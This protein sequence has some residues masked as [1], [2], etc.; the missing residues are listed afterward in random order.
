[1]SV[2]PQVFRKTMSC[3]AT[4]VTVVTARDAARA[5]VGL[6]VSA[7]SSLS[8]D[9]PLV[10]VCLD[11]RV[12]NLEAFRAG[13]FAVNVLAEDQS[14]ISQRF[15]EK[16]DDR[17][18]GVPLISGDSEPPLLAGT[19]AAVVCNTHQVVPSGDH[20]IIIGSVTAAT[21]DPDRRPLL[22][23]SGRYGRLAT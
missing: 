18:D 2:D 11:R 23:F 5:P 14:G 4:G 3:F 8:L 16:R 1:M 13:P 19:L 22:H 12:R 9:P 15:A 7:F 21:A 20:E 6:T 10:L 17:F